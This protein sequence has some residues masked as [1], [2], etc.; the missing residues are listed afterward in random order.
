MTSFTLAILTTATLLLSVFVPSIHASPIGIEIR[1][2][3]QQQQQQQQHVKR[4]CDR[5]LYYADDQDA[6]LPL[7][8]QGTWVHLKNQ[9]SS[10]QR[11][12]LSY[13]GQANA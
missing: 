9:G 1:Q 10:V 5:G 13:T 8:Y 6:K 11:G 3:Q 7:N 4:Q 12:T 2:T